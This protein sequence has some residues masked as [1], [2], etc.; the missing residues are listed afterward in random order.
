MNATI[1]SFI[2]PTFVTFP[3]SQNS[4]VSQWSMSPAGINDGAVALKTAAT[5]QR[6]AASEID[7]ATVASSSAV[8]GRASMVKDEIRSY[9]TLVDGWEG[10]SSLAPSPRHLE[11]A[12]E[13]IDRLPSGIPIPK[14]M[15]SSNGTVG[16][17]WDSHFSFADIEID[18]DDSLSLFVR[19][20]VEPRSEFFH[21]SVPITTASSAWLLEHLS[22]VRRNLA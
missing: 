12:I 1:S 9:L 17:Y 3:R 20:K 22:L 11:L 7:L 15:L 19:K 14:A 6:R 13:I 21:D 5:R 18:G 16:L 4:V 10:A 2:T 8:H